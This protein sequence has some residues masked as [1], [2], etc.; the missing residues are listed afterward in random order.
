MK[1]DNYEENCEIKGVLDELDFVLH[2]DNLNEILVVVL[3][4]IREQIVT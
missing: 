4:I 3:E 2:G 1:D